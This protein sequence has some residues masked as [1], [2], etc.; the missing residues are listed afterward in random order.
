MATT[1]FPAPGHVIHDAA[2][3]INRIAVL[4]DG[5]EKIVVHL[6][7]QTLAEIHDM[8]QAGIVAVTDDGKPVTRSILMRRALEYCKTLDMPVFVHA[9]DLDLAEGGAMRA[10]LSVNAL[11]VLVLGVVPAPLMDLCARAITASL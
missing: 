6:E 11:A 1:G 7:G 9:E 2:E 4:A 5:K 10:L 3:G 8:K